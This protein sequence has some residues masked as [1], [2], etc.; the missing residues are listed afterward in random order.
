MCMGFLLKGWSATLRY[1][2]SIYF[3]GHVFIFTFIVLGTVCNMALPHRD[4]GG[5]SVGG[6]GDGRHGKKR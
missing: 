4:S 1:W 3:I 5:S 6:G 2:N